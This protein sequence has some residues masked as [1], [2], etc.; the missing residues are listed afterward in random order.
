MNKKDQA[1]LKKHFTQSDDLMTVRRISTTFIDS[2]KQM[3]CHSVRLTLMS[4]T[5]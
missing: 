3:R 5:R 4:R 1:E 2:E